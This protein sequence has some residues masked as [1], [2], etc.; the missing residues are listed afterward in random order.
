M[1][2]LSQGIERKGIEKGIEKGIVASIVNVM[3]NLKLSIEEAIIAVGVPES[4]RNDYA[5]KLYKKD[6]I[7]I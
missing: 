6:T 5:A 3:N 4:E 7:S 2:N 1:C